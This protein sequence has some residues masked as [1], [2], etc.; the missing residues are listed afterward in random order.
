VLHPKK[1]FK[2][3]PKKAGKAVLILLALFAVIGLISI[4]SYLFSGSSQ[5]DNSL[6]P[7]G[8]NP[9]ASQGGL[10]A[11]IV[12]GLAQGVGN[13]VGNSGGLARAAMNRFVA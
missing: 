6:P 8:K 4:L 12:G 2:N 1:L 13:A 3:Q 10:G 9:Y 5:K 7:A 11:G